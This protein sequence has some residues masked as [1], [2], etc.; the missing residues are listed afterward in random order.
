MTKGVRI[1]Q[2]ALCSL[3]VSCVLTVLGTSGCALPEKVSEQTFTSRTD[4]V[5]VQRAREGI[6]ALSVNRFEEAEMKLRQAL[7]LAPGAE[8]IRLNLAAALEG[9]EQF[10]EA[11]QLIAPFLIKDPTSLDYQL[12][13]AH[14]EASKENYTE[15][16][17]IYKTILATQE[18]KKQW[19]DA[20][21]TA[22]NLKLLA[23]QTGS[24][25][26][27]LCYS[28][29]SFLYQNDLSSAVEHIRFLFSFDH[30]E[31]AL[32]TLEGYAAA[33]GSSNHPSILHLQALAKVGRS[34]FKDAWD[35]EV[36]ATASGNLDPTLLREAKIIRVVA[37][38]DDSV[39][40]QLTEEER[41]EL[42]EDWEKVKGTINAE[43][44]EISEWPPLFS[45]RV[46]AL[47]QKSSDS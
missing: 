13:K 14:L 18:D 9:T 4:L 37:G 30:V 19:T 16:R 21:R 40:S 26:E 38:E 22:R 44:S 20:A 46:L 25:E 5:A 1:V 15:A 3:S 31:S 36:R 28:S 32:T 45:E 35:D 42:I 6:Y 33:N 24:V 43:S 7:Y 10:K 41:E 8:N 11:D 12:R 39:K 34:K 27:A 17:G 47:I 2:L 29:L 23:V